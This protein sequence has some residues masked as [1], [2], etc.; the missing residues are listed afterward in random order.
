MK[1]SLKKNKRYSLHAKI[2][3]EGY[4][5]DSRTR[6]IYVGFSK[7]DSLSR[8]VLMLRDEFGYAIQTEIE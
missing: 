8:H 7:R 5:F 6:T 2:K 4:R 1:S 3:K